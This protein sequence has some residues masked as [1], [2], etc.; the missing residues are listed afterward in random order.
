MNLPR[1]IQRENC[2][3]VGKK[4]KNSAYYFKSEKT[5]KNQ[6]LKANHFLLHAKTKASYKQCKNCL[7]KTKA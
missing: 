7:E 4:E 2:P 1:T 5:S 6:V 3:S